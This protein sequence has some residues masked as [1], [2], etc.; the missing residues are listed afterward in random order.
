VH[1]YFSTINFPSLWVWTLWH[2]CRIICVISTASLEW[3]LI[4]WSHWNQICDLISSNLW[5]IS[6]LICC[7]EEEQLFEFHMAN[8]ENACGASLKHVSAF[9]WDHNEAF[10]QFGGPLCVLPRGLAVLMDHL[11]KG[12]DIRLNKQVSLS[13]H[14]DLHALLYCLARYVIKPLIIDCLLQVKFS[15]AI[16]KTQQTSCEK[17]KSDKL[18]KV[19]TKLTVEI[20]SMLMSVHYTRCWQT[21]R[22]HCIACTSD[23]KRY[24]INDISV[25]KSISGFQT[26]SPHLG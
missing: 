15:L 11:A 23:V 13:Y 25:A 16:N 9:H 26:A 20:F 12:I 10:A 1:G 21:C 19:S 3:R 5:Y 18:K 8:L 22:K 4:V 14:C 2:W 24:P 17:A 6:L 7:Q